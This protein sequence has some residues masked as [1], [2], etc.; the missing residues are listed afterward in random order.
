MVKPKTTSVDNLTKGIGKASIGGGISM[1]KSS[2]IVGLS[3]LSKTPSTTSIKKST[4]LHVF[5]N[6]AAPKL[7]ILESPEGMREFLSKD[8]TSRKLAVE[9][10]INSAID[11]KCIFPASD[12]TAVVKECGLLSPEGILIINSI[13]SSVNNKSTNL[14]GLLLTLD[15]LLK[16]VGRSIEPFA[17]PLIPQLFNLSSHKT[18]GIRDFVNSIFVTLSDII[19][20]FS[21]RSIYPMLVNAL[22]TSD[23]KIKIVGLEF[24]KNFAPRVSTQITPL[25]VQIIPLVSEC[26]G[27]PKRPVQL[28]GMESLTMACKSIT[29]ED[30]VGLV[31]QLVSVIGNPDEADKTLDSLL[32]TTFV[33]NVDAATL[34]LI[35][36]LLGK[37]LKGRS[38]PLKRKAAR[39]IDN[40]CRLVQEPAQVAPFIPLLLP[41]LEKVIDEIA[42]EEVCGVAVAARIV[43]MNASDEGKTKTSI[44]ANNKSSLVYSAVKFNLSDALV[45]TL[46][47]YDNNRVASA[48]VI[49]YIANSCAQ[50]LVYNT[51]NQ[52]SDIGKPEF[53]PWRLA[54]SMSN[55]DEWRDCVEPYISIFDKETENSGETLS[56]FYRTK[57]LGNVADFSAEKDLEGSNLCNIEFSLAFG[58]K[59]LLH[60]TRLK[61][62]IGKRYAV[63]GKNGAG[64]T[65]LLTNIGTGN[66]EGLPEDLKTVYVQHD[67][68]TEDLGVPLVDEMIQGRD[69]KDVGVTREEARKALTDINFTEEMIESPRSA[70]SGGW[71]MK[72]LIIRA[73][74]SKAD[75]L[76][77][78]EPTNHLDQASVQ[79]LV[80]YLQEKENITCLIVSHDTSFLDKVVTDVIHYETRK[81]VYYSGNIT[82]F[83]KIKPEAKYYFELDGES[84]KFDFPIPERLDGINSTTRAI[85]TLKN[86]TYTYPGTT[87]PVI[88]N[89]NIKLCLASRVAVTGANGAGKSTLI[90]MLVQETKPDEDDSGVDKLWKHHNLRIAYVAQHSLHH[91][92]QHMD[93][94]PVDYIKWRFAG[95][96]DKEDLMKQNMKLTE[97]EEEE[98]SD[99]KYG[100]IIE[101]FGRR[102][103]GRTMEYECSF[104]GQTPRDDNRY[105]C[106]EKLIERGYQKLITAA[107][108][109]IAARA[110]GLEVRPLLIKEIQSHLDNFNLESEFGTH[111]KIRR[112]SGGQKVKLVLAAAMWNRPHLIILDEPTNY[113]DREALGALTQAIKNFAGGVAIISHNAEFTDTLCTE[114]WLV[115]DGV[116]NISGEAVESVMQGVTEKKQKKTDQEKLEKGSAKQHT[117]A[118]CTNKTLDISDLKNPKSLEP[119]SKKEIRKLEK[120]ALSAGVPLREYVTKITRFSPEYKW[121][122]GP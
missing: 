86:A 46:D 85:I 76:L 15:L 30:I 82:E 93:E 80:T 101:I 91:V 7:S 88:S 19:C 120:C 18:Q 58:G 31:P 11:S 59:I 40:M 100:D 34:A 22:E 49:S 115:K 97:E 38:S 119:F 12:L 98:R 99:K 65:T 28:L 63:M 37:A 52:H 45:E 71:K 8:E 78:D 5:K 70:L 39:V 47:G 56:A 4:S 75:V 62:G 26:I 111:S 24:L 50:L 61:L 16:N 68:S 48:P 42:D 54:L 21:F 89:A 60:N 79:W 64:K 122:S 114:K 95:G 84:M 53:E 105:I 107:D 117:Q 103:N 102:K 33:S 44:I 25:L 108:L 14:E 66:I 118:G 20:P 121:L 113:L 57:S 35:A 73:M 13:T 96:A 69:L 41:A 92:E 83:V 104:V 23:W 72:V 74:L 110:A 116:C 112:L 106:M 81:L 2:S 36:P 94:S 90:R 55:I 1:A 17:F 109:K 10:L 32:E 51:P 6:V 9:K 67:D 43:L 77:L 87:K 27:S 3:S 29:N